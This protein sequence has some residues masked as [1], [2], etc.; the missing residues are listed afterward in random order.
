MQGLDSTEAKTLTQLLND[1]TGSSLWLDLLRLM[2]PNGV[3]DTSQMKNELHLDHDRLRYLI[4]QIQTISKGSPPV[5]IDTGFSTKRAGQ[6]G[7]PST[8]YRLGES[9]AALL[10]LSGVKDARACQLSKDHELQHAVFMLDVRQAAQHA[11][12]SVHTDRR[13]E[14]GDRRYIRPD[15]LIALPDGSLAIFEIEQV[16]EPEWIPR[17]VESLTNKRDFFNSTQGK[18]FSPAIRMILNASKNEGV[19]RSLKIWAQGLRF[20]TG[21]LPLPFQLFVLP[22]NE[23]LAR[24]DWSSEPDPERW[25]E[26]KASTAPLARQVQQR[27]Q[28]LGKNQKPDNFFTRTM[29]EDHL[30][31]SAILRDWQKTADGQAKLPDPTFFKIIRLIYS[32]S[33]RPNR[34]ALE[35]SSVPYA[36]LQLL[37]EYLD[38]HP[39]LT[40]MLNRAIHKNGGGMRWM[41]ATITHRMQVVVNRF[42]E[43]HGLISE[44]AMM[45]SA[46][47]SSNDQYRNRKFDVQ[48]RILRIEIL[49]DAND[50]FS[51]SRKDAAVAATALSWVLRAMFEYSHLLGIQESGFW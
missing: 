28:G 13:L 17:I 38:L 40:E 47:T 50:D 5:I 44:G 36:S 24:P 7:K 11:G 31:L 16:A 23:F 3:T 26:V 33:H 12:L 4:E 49:R 42:L 32:A 9:G 2:S 46:D 8:I 27:S 45:V 21:E 18:A 34:S 19:A 48:V 22:L 30:L 25:T 51:P 41:P 35:E 1:R 37:Q 15:N 20:I 39:A 29:D 43:Y 10:R 6:R 14:Y